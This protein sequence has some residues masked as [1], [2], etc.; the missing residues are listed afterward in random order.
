M[1]AVEIAA[2]IEEMGLEPEIFAAD[3]R[4]PAEIGGAVMPFGL[5]AVFDA[6]ANGIDPGC[7]PEVIGEIDIG[8]WK[9]DRAAELVA[10]IDAAID[11]PRPAQQ[12][13]RLAWPAGDEML[14]DMGRGIDDSARRGAT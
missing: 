5:A 2:E 11:F 7:R 9:A 8:R 3:R 1:L 10:D 6:S 14:A 12:R 4:P 13:G